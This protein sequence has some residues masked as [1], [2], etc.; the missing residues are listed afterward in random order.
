MTKKGGTKR[1]R[2]SHH[3]CGCERGQHHANNGDDVF[4]T[5]DCNSDNTRTARSSSIFHNND[6]TSIDTQKIRQSPRPSSASSSSVLKCN[7]RDKERATLVILLA[8]MLFSSSEIFHPAT[9]RKRRSVIVVDAICLS[10][11]SSSSSRHS[12]S[13][14]FQIASLPTLPWGRNIRQFSSFQ[15][16]EQRQRLKMGSI[17]AMSPTF[18]CIG[19]ASVHLQATT[20]PDSSPSSSGSDEHS[21]S[22]PA[23]AASIE[24]G[25]KSK[26]S[27]SSS[28]SSKSSKNSPRTP[29][30]TYSAR[31]IDDNGLKLRVDDDGITTVY[32]RDDERKEDG[33]DKIND[34]SSKD[35]NG[36]VA[37]SAGDIADGDD[38]VVS[39]NNGQGS[40]TS[41]A[42]DATTATIRPSVQEQS[43][44][45]APIQGF[46]VVLT[47]CTADFDS[48]ASAVGLAKLWSSSSHD[49][50]EDGNV[51]DGSDNINEVSDVPN[52]NQNEFDSYDKNKFPTFVVLPR[53]AHPSVQRFLA[54]HK[55]LFPIR[56]L[57]SLPSDLSG[58]NRLALVDAQ[59]RDRIGP[60]EPL[61]KHANRVTVVDHHV[62]SESDIPE[63]TDYVVDKVGSVSTLIV[64]RLMEQHQ[65]KLHQK[66]H[67]KATTAESHSSPSSLSTTIPDLTLGDTSSTTSSLDSSAAV[68][69]G[70]TEAEATLLA[71]GIHADTGSLCYDSTTP[72]DAAALAWVMAQGASQ[73]AIA[74][75]AQSSLSQEQQGVLTQALINTNSTV[76]HGVTVSTVLLTADGF[77][78]GLAAV[79]QDAMELSSSDVYLLG[80]VYEPKSGGQRKSSRKKKDPSERIKS[81]L[82]SDTPVM[83]PNQLLLSQN[84]A[85]G[86]EDGSESDNNSLIQNPPALETVGWKGGEEALLR[87]RLR[88]AFDRKDLDGSGCLDI[89]EL[90]TALAASGIIVTKDS[91]QNLM[92]T[93]DI[94]QDGRIDF[95][96]FVAFAKDAQSSMTKNDSSGESSDKASNKHS[97]LIIIG[98][99]K[100]GVNLKSI[101]LGKLLEKYGGG[102][103]AK[104]ASATVRLNDESEAAGVLSGLVDELV[105]TGLNAQPTVGDFMTAPVLSV[106]ADMTELQVEDLFTRYDVRSLPVVDHDNNVIGLVTYKEVAAAK[107]RLWNKE[108]KRLREEQKNQKSKRSETSESSEINDQRK[109]LSK[110][111][112]KRGT[113]VKAWMLQHVMVVEA[114]RTMAEVE[115]VLIENDVGCV[116]V[117]EDGSMQLVGMVTRTDILRQHRYYPSLHYNNKGMSDSIANRKSLRLVEL[118]RVLK[119]LDP[120]V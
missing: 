32:H 90:S 95:E 96:E 49:D 102:G 48:L 92:D 18:S 38:E 99:A 77:I 84:G 66:R 85:T 53:G 47:H 14:R 70:L 73:A 37:S 75:H 12:R 58:L 27:S 34:S 15:P 67:K 97:T 25:S 116:P 2:R 26:S 36:V 57:K 76:V 71:L 4:F 82:L 6:I 101:K 22:S 8:A 19:R 9:A 83:R 119:K 35:K 64:E 3:R 31:Y 40:G 1:I 78:N 41:T 69:D 113:T 16:Q 107:Q 74:E 120:D 10:S 29:F 63:A 88:A 104:A 7:N 80:L 81:R 112:R 79:T 46:N 60:A 93:I 20:A 117:V 44:A 98:R 118:R 54:L 68:E 50:D 23:T 11:R 17:M 72:R 39:D 13:N 86:G 5:C 52:Q 24:K 87:K 56:S 110:E 115:A 114:S 111:R 30:G 100:P 108:Q 28:S 89:R 45:I 106:G 65:K 42:G 109:E 61:L 91:V 103:H 55:H 62:D 21:S 43:V 94:N 105:A 33:Q 51:I 59:R